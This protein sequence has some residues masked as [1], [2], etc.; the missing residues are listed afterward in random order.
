[1]WGLSFRLI[2]FGGE[3]HDASLCP[4][5]WTLKS[6]PIYVLQPEVF[7]RVIFCNFVHNSSFRLIPTNFFEINE[8]GNLWKVALVRIWWH[9]L[10]FIFIL[11]LFSMFL[12]GVVP[13]RLV[14]GDIPN[15]GTVE[16]YHQCFWGTISSRGWSIKEANVICRQL[17]Y[18]S[19]S[20]AWQNAHFGQGSGP[21][22][23]ANVVCNGEES[24]ID[25]CDHSGWFQYDYYDYYDYYDHYNDAGVTCDLTTP[26][27]GEMIPLIIH[28]D[29]IISTSSS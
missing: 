18:P 12:P 9:Q 26:L 24:S 29:S 27:P 11:Y 19:A 15:E 6:D 17:G 14:R 5:F 25:Q 1:M 7:E 10:F 28:F 8:I 3:S 2:C 4:R 22:L 13:V 23:L 20:Q 16:V 21:I